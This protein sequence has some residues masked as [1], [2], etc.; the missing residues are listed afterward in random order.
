MQDA[1]WVFA[2][3]SLMWRPGFPVAETRPATVYGYHRAMC[4]W[5]HH[6]R[7]TR[8]KP[9]LVLGLDRGGSCQGLALRVAKSRVEAVTGYLHRRELMGGDVYRPMMLRAR[10]ADGRRVLVYAFVANHDHHQYAGHL[11][12]TRTAAII[13]GAKGRLGSN[14]AYLANTVAH[15]DA[16]GLADNN[17]R[18]LLRAVDG[19]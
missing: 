19:G 3:G 2:Y 9:G 15:L 11:R 7:G 5:S 6:Y 12:S 4:I 14:R 16:M 1:F 13:R 18:H 10:F 17:L 8:K